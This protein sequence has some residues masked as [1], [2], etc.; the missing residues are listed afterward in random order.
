MLDK[1][2]AASGANEASHSAVKIN[3]IIKYSNKQHLMN[4]LNS[5]R[6]QLKKHKLN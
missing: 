3:K 2:I 4:K 1:L 6:I 5:M